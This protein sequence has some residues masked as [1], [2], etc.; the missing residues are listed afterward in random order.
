MAPYTWRSSV[1]STHAVSLCALTN[2][3]SRNGLKPVNRQV[4]LTYPDYRRCSFVVLPVSDLFATVRSHGLGDR[5]VRAVKLTVAVEYRGAGRLICYSYGRV[6]PSCAESALYSLSTRKSEVD[7]FAQLMRSPAMFAWSNRTPM[8]VCWSDLR[9]EDGPGGTH[10]RRRF[11][12]FGREFECLMGKVFMVDGD[13]IM[14]MSGGHFEGRFSNRKGDTLPVVSHSKVELL[15]EYDRPFQGV[16][17]IVEV[18]VGVG[19]DDAKFSGDEYVE[20]QGISMEL[21]RM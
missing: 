16:N 21:I 15:I 8:S 19:V 14:G 7:V 6:P 11:L 2:G 13:S 5:P 20:I 10:G 3:P 9:V 1:R 4:Y 17:G 18:L 12:P